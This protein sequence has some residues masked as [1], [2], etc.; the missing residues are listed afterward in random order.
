MIRLITLNAWCG[1]SLYPLM[2][3][4][5][6]KSESTDIFCLQEIQSCDQETADARHPEEHICGPL[7]SKINDAL[8]DF[9]GSFASFDDD[10]HRMSLALFWRR[11]LPV[12]E[13]KDFIVYKPETP[14]ETGSKIASPRKLQYMT[15][16]FDKKELLL[17]NYHGLWDGGSK[18]DT[19]A[20]IHQ[21]EAIRNFLDKFD[22]PKILCGDFNLLPETKSL[23]ILERGMQN[24]VKEHNIES[25]RTVLYRHHDSPTQPNFADYI[26]ASP[27]IMV[28][29]FEVL[30]DIV[31][32]H[33]PLYLEFEVSE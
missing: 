8:N 33:S 14:I 6:K 10:P 16:E 21:S 9:E 25:T 30:P 24:L 29:K 20:R 2:Q 23:N 12:K 5:R 32:D 22:G 26:I 4:L 3:F 17:A 31:S 7:F 11:D 18:T 13:V 1:R 27:E 28:K 15:L 19:V